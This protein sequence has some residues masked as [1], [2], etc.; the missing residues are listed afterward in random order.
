MTEATQITEANEAV[1]ASQITEANEAVE[2]TEL[3]QTI[4]EKFANHIASLE[5]SYDRVHKVR[6]H[7]TFARIEDHLSQGSKILELG[8]K[9][10]IALFLEDQGFD[11]QE[12]TKDL[13][14]KFEVED[15][16][17]DCIFL[18]EVYEHIKDREPLPEDIGS[19][20][21]FTFSGIHNLLTEMKR[22]TKNGGIIFLTTPNA[23]SVDAIARLIKNKPPFGF[24]PHVREYAPCEVRERF[25]EQGYSEISFSTFFAWNSL[26]GIN[27]DQYLEFLRSIDEDTGNRGDD[28][29]FAFQV[30]K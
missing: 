28:M 23:C 30:Q 18:F 11:V 21:T 3:T 7:N 19:I 6:Y 25:V 27:R 17:F 24:T 16:S 5:S 20:A 13:R 9:S 14:Y 26:P 15:N 8:G 29:F 1:E 12:Y 10:Q 22:V 4:Q 2:A